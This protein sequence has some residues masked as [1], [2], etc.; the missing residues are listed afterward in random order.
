M[1]GRNGIRFK[2]MKTL[3]CRLTG[4]CCDVLRN[5]CLS[6]SPVSYSFHVIPCTP[7]A[8]FRLSA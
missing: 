2:S 7:G 5:A 4:F 6:S 1:A 3:S 8:A